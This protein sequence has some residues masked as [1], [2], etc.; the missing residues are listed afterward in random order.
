[1]ENTDQKVKGSQ[2][3][4][5]LA[6]YLP[7]F[8]QSLCRTLESSGHFF[9]RNS[10]VLYRID[11]DDRSKNVNAVTDLENFQ[12]LYKFYVFTALEIKENLPLSVN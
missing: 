1:M 6:N 5:N 9:F 7:V 11:S 3:L 2:L 8:T 4:R 12:H 10:G